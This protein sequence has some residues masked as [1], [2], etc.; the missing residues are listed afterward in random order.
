MDEQSRRER[1]GLIQG[2]VLHSGPRREVVLFLYEG[3]LWVADFFD[4]ESQLVDATTWVRFN[5]EGA[6]NGRTRLPEAPPPLSIYQLVRIRALAQG[7]AS[8]SL[9]ASIR[10]SRRLPWAGWQAASSVST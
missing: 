9:L 4:G 6:A 1:R 10:P 7:A 3:M 8:N 5:C 2:Q